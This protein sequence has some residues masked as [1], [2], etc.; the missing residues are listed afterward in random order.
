MN[1]Q[2]LIDV[3]NLLM[4]LRIG[5]P[6]HL[7]EEVDKSIRVIQRDINIETTDYVRGTQPEE[8]RAK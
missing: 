2:E 6:N 4:K 7:T 8:F 3:R 5:L 1:P